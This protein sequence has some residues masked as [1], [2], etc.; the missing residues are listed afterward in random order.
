MLRSKITL[1][2]ICFTA[3]LIV[4]PFYA[5]AFNERLEPQPAPLLRPEENRKVIIFDNDFL[6]RRFGQKPR[7]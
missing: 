4:S 2:W 5:S 1:C 3:S 6:D 7:S